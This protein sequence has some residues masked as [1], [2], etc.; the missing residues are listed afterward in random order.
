MIEAVCIVDERISDTQWFQI[1]W[2]DASMR[3]VD[4][5]SVMPLESTSSTNKR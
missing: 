3:N 4:V 5:N 1:D 2:R